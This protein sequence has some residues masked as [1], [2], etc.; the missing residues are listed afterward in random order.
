M[1]VDDTVYVPQRLQMYFYKGQSTQQTGSWLLLQLTSLEY[2]SI[3]QTGTLWPSTNPFDTKFPHLPL[4]VLCM[5]A[6]IGKAKMIYQ[7]FLGVIK[8][9]ES[10][11]C[12]QGL[13][14]PVCTEPSG[15]RS[16]VC[17]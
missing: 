5:Q 4:A 16:L 3:T 2:K 11:W 15:L 1:G 10:G 17:S 13:C 8:L 7:L 12:C 14:A 9:Y 6:K